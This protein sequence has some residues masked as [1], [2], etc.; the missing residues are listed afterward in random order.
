MVKEY[1]VIFR[2]RGA[3]DALVRAVGGIYLYLRALE[4]ISEYYQIYGRVVH[5]KHTRSGSREFLPVLPYSRYRTPERGFIVAYRLVTGDRLFQREAEHRAPA[6]FA[7]HFQRAS[8]E[9]QQAVGYGDAETRAFDVPVVRFVYALKRR[10]QLRYI[11]FPYTY[12]GVLYAHVEHYAVRFA[13]YVLTADGEC[14]G[15]LFGVLHRV[16]EDIRDRLPYAYLVAAQMIGHTAVYVQHK[17]ETLFLGLCAQHRHKIVQH[18]RKLIVNG[19]YVELSRFY[20]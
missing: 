4:K 2:L 14:D 18:C 6:E 13:G 7:R 1:Y 17:S 5:H 19:D 20:L 10:E 11:L 3:C 16:G 12:A 9:P 15:T 8:H